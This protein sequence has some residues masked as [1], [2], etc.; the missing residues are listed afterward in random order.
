MRSAGRVKRELRDLSETF[1]G[2]AIELAQIAA[3]LG[4]T[5]FAANLLLCADSARKCAI[6]L[7]LLADRAIEVGE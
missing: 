6:G 7:R 5:E 3:A 2:C 1:D 4:P